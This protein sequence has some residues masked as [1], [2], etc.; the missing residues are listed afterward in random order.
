M[1]GM[2]LLIL[3]LALW[4][5]AHLVKRLAPAMRD[6]LGDSGRGPIALAILGG[7]ILMVVGYRMADSH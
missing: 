3:G 6:D 7:L 4:S 1:M 5:G 2:I